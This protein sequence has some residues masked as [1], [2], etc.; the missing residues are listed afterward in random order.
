[1]QHLLNSAT[2]AFENSEGHHL[3][4]AEWLGHVACIAQAECVERGEA[5]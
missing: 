2:V 4:E 5:G 1:M 3:I